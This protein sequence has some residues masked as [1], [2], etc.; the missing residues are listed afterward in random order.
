[1]GEMI[2][3]VIITNLKVIDVVG[4]DV[5][6]AMKAEDLGYDGFGEAYFSIIKKGVI[7]GWKCHKK[8]TLNIVVPLGAVRFKIFDDRKGSLTYGDCQEVFLS[9]VN[10]RR[11]TIPPMVWIGFQGSDEK[12]SMLLNIANIPHDPGEMVSKKLNE[13]DIDWESG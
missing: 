12:D 5:L 8:M 4:G 10:Y 13:I 3:G 6:H 7:K 1:M 9:R 11:L 2:E